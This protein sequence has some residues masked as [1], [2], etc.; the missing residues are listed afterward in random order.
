MLKTLLLPSLPLMP[1]SDSV[2]H[3]AGPSQYAGSYHIGGG[4]QRSLSRAIV[5]PGG[6][7]SSAALHRP[8]EADSDSISQAAAGSAERHAATARRRWRRQHRRPPR[9]ARRATPADHRPRPKRERGSEQVADRRLN[10]TCPTCDEDGA[11]EEIEE[12]QNGL[13]IYNHGRAQGRPAR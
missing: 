3:G 7:G 6:N 5:E 4:G 11:A 13:G 9:V 8:A 12:E 2:S 10:A 1:S